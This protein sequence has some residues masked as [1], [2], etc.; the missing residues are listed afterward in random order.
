MS[1]GRYFFCS[2]NNITYST[3]KCL[4]TFCTTG[5]GCCYCS[6][7]FCMSFGRYFFCSYNNITYS[8]L[9]CL[10]TF[11]NTGCCCCYCSAVFCVIMCFIIDIQ[12]D[13]TCSYFFTRFRIILI[14]LVIPDMLSNIL[15]MLFSVTA[16]SMPVLCAVC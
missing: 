10:Y 7:V 9:K 1:F 4:Y 15:V 12:A 8:T 2:Y 5:W 6:A 14:I 11:C 16:C 3:L 13:C